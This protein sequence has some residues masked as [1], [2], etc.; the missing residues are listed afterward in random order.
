MAEPGY[1]HEDPEG[2]D[3]AGLI[4]ALEANVEP[5]RGAGDPGREGGKQGV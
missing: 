2:I 3:E 4:G 1:G 5:A